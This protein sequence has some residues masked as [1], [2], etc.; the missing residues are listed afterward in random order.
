MRR[1]RSIAEIPGIGPLTIRILTERGVQTVDELAKIDPYD[2]R[3]RVLGENLLSYVYYARKA[4]ADQV[5]KEVTVTPSYIKV[6]CSK[7]FDAEA[8]RKAVMGRLEIYDLYVDWKVKEG[9][10]RWEFTFTLKPEFARYA[11]AD[12]QQ[13]MFLA[14]ELRRQLQLRERK[15]GKGQPG[16]QFRMAKVLEPLPPP[17]RDLLEIFC[18][19]QLISNFNLLVILDKDCVNRSILR[20]FLKAYTLKPVHWICGSEDMEGLTMTMVSSN[21]GTMFLEGVHN[22]RPNEKVMLLSLLSSGAVVK[23]SSGEVVE[24]PVRSN[25][26]TMIQLGEEPLPDRE[27]LGLYHLAIRL[28]PLKRGT[29]LR[30]VEMLKPRLDEEFR[31]FVRERMELSPGYMPMPEGIRVSVKQ[32]NPPRDLAGFSV[33]LQE[34]VELLARASAKFNASPS[35]TVQDYKKAW[36]MVASAL[37]T[38]S[39]KRKRL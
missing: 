29:Q 15:G 27:M 39:G 8:T 10:D 20:N 28:P 14:G 30:Q 35:I 17:F 38:L 22:A 12:W 18:H 23:E 26:V 21:G 2:E 31:E 1:E 32:Y 34:A 19:M 25:V 11:L 37:Q 3:F 4:I 16:R 9:K 7:D 24:I 36:K 33:R 5:I 13:Y 6:V